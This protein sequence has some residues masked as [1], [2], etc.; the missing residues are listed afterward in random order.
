VP[1]PLRRALKETFKQQTMTDLVEC[2]S[3]QEYA[4]RPLALHWQGKRLPIIEIVTR[5]RTLHGKAFLVRTTD[6]QV[7]QLS[8]DELDQ[9]WC[10]EPFFME[11][12]H[13]SRSKG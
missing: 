3:G 9:T 10:I 11:E 12:T 8:Y 7:F 2:Y 13:S 6:Q 1:N 4:E 5:W